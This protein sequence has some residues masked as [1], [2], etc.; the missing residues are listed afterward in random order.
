MPEDGA[1]ASLA[2]PIIPLACNAG[3]VAM[4]NCSGVGAFIAKANKSGSRIAVAGIADMA[5]IAGI[6]DIVGIAGIDG[7]AGIAGIDGSVGI[8]G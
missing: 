8:G 2:P 3:I 7:I 1:A 4:G 6:D 5:G